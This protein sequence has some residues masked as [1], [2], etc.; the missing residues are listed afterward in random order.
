MT[1]WTIVPTPTP[2]LLPQT[3]YS[4]MMNNITNSSFNIATMPQ[5]VLLPYGFATTFGL[6]IPVFLIMFGFFINMWLTQGNLKIV[7]MTGVLLSGLM[8][9]GGGIG[10]ALPPE[11]YPIIYGALIASISGYILSMFK[12]V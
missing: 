5:T 7:S 10:I 8:F 4:Y 2:T 1:Y 9:I 3:T 6:S 11:V 12:R